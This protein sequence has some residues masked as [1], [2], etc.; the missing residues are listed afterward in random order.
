MLGALES[1]SKDA[2]VHFCIEAVYTLRNS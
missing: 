2:A 1:M